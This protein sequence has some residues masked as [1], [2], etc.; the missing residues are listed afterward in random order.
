[1][2][3]LVAVSTYLVLGMRIVASAAPGDGLYPTGFP[4]TWA[5]APG[6]V[7]RDCADCS[8]MVV[9][10]AGSFTMG[11]SAEEK[12]WAASRWAAPKV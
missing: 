11:S 2:K 12:A 4:S 8:E 9:L 1:M 5:G 3:T 10:P 7:F 6:S